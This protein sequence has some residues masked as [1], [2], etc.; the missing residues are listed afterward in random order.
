[1]WS[2]ES[3]ARYQ[4]IGNRGTLWLG[5]VVGQGL[6]ARYLVGDFGIGVRFVVS[7]G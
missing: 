1:M 3:L 4:P 7:G 5:A 2:R 6:H